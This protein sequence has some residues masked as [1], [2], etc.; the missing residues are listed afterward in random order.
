MTLHYQF[1]PIAIEYEV[2]IKK[3]NVFDFVIKF[4]HETQFLSKT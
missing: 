3:L 1:L 2:I 4:Y